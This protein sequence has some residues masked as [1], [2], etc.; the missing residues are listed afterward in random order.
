[1]QVDQPGYGRG[2]VNSTWQNHAVAPQRHIRSKQAAREVDHVSVL[3]IFWVGRLATNIRP[4]I[5]R[6]RA[7]HSVDY[8]SEMNI[9]QASIITHSARLH[10][11]LVHSRRAINRNFARINGES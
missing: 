4:K 7:L 6:L 2:P 1:M 9:A 5:N 8:A 3:N 11:C 10:N